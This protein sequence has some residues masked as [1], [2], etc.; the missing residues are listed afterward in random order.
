MVKQYG[1][2]R[3]DQINLVGSSVCQW[4]I[5]SNPWKNLWNFNDGCWIPAESP[6]V[7]AH[8]RLAGMTPELCI[9]LRLKSEVLVLR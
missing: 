6:E 2:N 3:D 7:Y 4:Q 1:I 9:Y 5:L 8:Y